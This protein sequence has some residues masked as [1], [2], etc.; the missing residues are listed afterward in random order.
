MEIL[1]FSMGDYEEAYALWSD[2]PGIGL[3][4]ADTRDAIRVYLQRNPGTSFVAREDGVLVGAV[5]SGHDG[6]R[7][8]IHHLAVAAKHQ[9]RGLGTLLTDRCL[10][11]LETC[12]IAKCHVFVFRKNA[13]AAGFWES[14]R[15]E[16]RDDIVVFSRALD[17]TDMH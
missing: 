11:A 3:S 13:A 7:G 6:R 15:W 5:L 4:G 8:Y 9:G 1:P 16:R 17:G 10:A 12:G 14:A 2:L